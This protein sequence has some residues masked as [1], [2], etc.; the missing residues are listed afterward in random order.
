MPHLIRCRQTSRFSFFFS[1]CAF[2]CFSYCTPC[3]LLQKRPSYNHCIAL[4]HLP[5]ISRAEVKAEYLQHFHAS[6]HAAKHSKSLKSVHKQLLPS[7]SSKREYD[8][9]ILECCLQGIFKASFTQIIDYN[10]D[11]FVT[12]HFSQV[13]RY[14]RLSA[15]LKKHA[16]MN[17]SN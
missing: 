12:E 13:F 16:F 8:L 15:N 3:L 1:Q 2:I 11:H 17:I 10:F 4:S 9:V 14:L 6:F 5:N 7:S